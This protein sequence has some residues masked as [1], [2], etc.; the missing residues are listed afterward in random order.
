MGQSLPSAREWA[1]ICWPGCAGPDGM[2]E[3]VV[4]SH[5]V[6][7]EAGWANSAQ[8]R[9][10]GDRATV[11]GQTLRLNLHLQKRRDAH[12]E[13]ELIEMLRAQ[14]SG[15]EVSRPASAWMVPREA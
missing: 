6:S 3:S 9:S 10:A 2:M 8:T 7:Y 5:Q 15:L 14:P 4:A 12:A 11:M 1:R 13:E